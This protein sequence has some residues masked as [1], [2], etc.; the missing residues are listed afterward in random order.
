MPCILA[1][2]CKLAQLDGEARF[3]MNEVPNVGQLLHVLFKTKRDS[4][5]VW[6]VELIKKNSS[7][8]SDD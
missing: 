3:G 6:I 2:V 8:L 4:D 7:G 5:G 1:S